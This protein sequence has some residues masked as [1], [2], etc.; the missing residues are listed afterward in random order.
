MLVD[1]GQLLKKRSELPPMSK[2]QARHAMCS[3]LRASDPQ[4]GCGAARA[5]QASTMAIK[6]CWRSRF[7]QFPRYPLREQASDL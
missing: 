4:L 1:D 5:K 7:D 2:I 3:P 6:L